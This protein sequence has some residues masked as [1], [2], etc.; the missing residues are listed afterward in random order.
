MSKRKNILIVICAAISTII[1]GFMLVDMWSWFIAVPF[2]IKP[3]NF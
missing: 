1:G 2:N 3:I